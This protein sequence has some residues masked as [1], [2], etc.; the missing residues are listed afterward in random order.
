MQSLRRQSVAH[1]KKAPCSHARSL[2]RF[3]HT[4]VTIF[5][6]HHDPTSKKKSD[7]KKTRRQEMDSGVP[8]DLYANCHTNAEHGQTPGPTQQP[9]KGKTVTT[10]H[11]PHLPTQ[12]QSCRNV[13][14]E[15]DG[16]VTGITRAFW[17]HHRTDG[18]HVVRVSPR[19]PRELGI[20]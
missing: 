3:Q 10:C 15:V 11:L 20:L 19:E 7:V 4:E 6:T 16:G 17:R 8:K 14:A 13:A 1:N 9:S 5:P 18:V 2:A 12:P